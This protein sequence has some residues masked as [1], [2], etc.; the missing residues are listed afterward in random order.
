MISRLPGS[1][2]RPS[3]RWISGRNSQAWGPTPRNVTLAPVPLPFCSSSTM[4]TA[5]AEAIGWPDAVFLIPSASSMV[6]TASRAS[7][8][9]SSEFEPPR[10][11][12]ARSGRPAFL[13]VWLK[14]TAIARTETS[15]ATTPA[16]PMTMTSEVPS[17]CG[18][19]RR[20]IRVTVPIWRN[21]LIALSSSSG[22]GIDQP[23][24]LEAPS[25]RQGGRERQHH[26][27]RDADGENAGRQARDADEP[28]HQ[29]KNRRG[30]GQT[31]QACD[32]A[33]HQR[34]AEDERGHAGA[35]KSQRLQH[36]ELGDPLHDGLHHG[37]AGE[38][39]EREEDC[40]DDQGHDQIDVALLLQEGLGV[41][42]LVLSPGLVG[43]IFE[44]LVDRSRDRGSMAGVVDLDDI[45][46]DRASAERPGFIEIAVI[47]QEIGVERLRTG[48]IVDADDIE[49]PIRRTVRFLGPDGR[50]QRHP[51][52][53]LPA[54]LLGQ[55]LADDCPAAGLD[56]SPELIFGQFQLGI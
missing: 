23:Q 7:V 33:Q 36:R 35:R 43:R 50:A 31:E 2:S 3:V 10:K 6:S 40:A 19:L 38:E 42:L 12:I 1:N 46:A 21:R 51:I 27:D 37:V 41:L 30:A 44:Q 54:I 32:Q 14:P 18:M 56:E 48:S 26:G 4:T 16:M 20:F 9:A 25:R 52:A 17:R 24:P 45:P 28:L 49:A 29:R 13:I 11:T 34:F 5:S 15:T 53:D 47:E 39:Q 55:I 22:Q 8:L